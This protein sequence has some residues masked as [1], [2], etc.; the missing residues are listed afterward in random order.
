V[1]HVW[2]RTW[3]AGGARES[4]LLKQGFEGVVGDGRRMQ[5]ATG[6][7]REHEVARVPLSCGEEPK[8]NPKCGV[9]VRSG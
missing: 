2:R 3:E 5:H 7:G 4:G 1:A 9:R 6:A 8:R